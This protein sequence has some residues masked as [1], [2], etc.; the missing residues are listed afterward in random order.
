MASSSTEPA[1][2]IQR[3]ITEIW[4]G[5]SLNT[6]SEV[7]ADE[8]TMYNPTLSL[9]AEGQE[10]FKNVVRTFRSSFPDL[11]VT[12]DDLVGEGETVAYR[13]TVRGTHQGDFLGIPPTGTEI[14]VD[15]MSIVH[16]E[17]GKAVEEWV[18][19]DVL[20]LMQQVGIAPAPQYLEQ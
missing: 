16:F 1:E 17:N 6:T 20:G 18:L 7:I 3:I 9:D 12:I 10:G 13:G 14:T 2:R 4:N 5:G 11:E 19:Y 15:V 8:Y